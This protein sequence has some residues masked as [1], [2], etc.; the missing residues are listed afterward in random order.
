VSSGF[1]VVTVFVL[2]ITASGRLGN[3]IFVIILTVPFVGEIQT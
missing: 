1:G 2:T 3:G